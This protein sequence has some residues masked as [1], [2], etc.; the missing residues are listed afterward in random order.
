MDIL[1]ILYWDAKVNPS[2]ELFC[3][4]LKVLFRET[5]R[6]LLLQLCLPS[7]IGSGVID[8]PKQFGAS[9]FYA[10]VEKHRVF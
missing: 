5:T 10:P 2:I 3:S 1:Y 9:T 7:L 8:G 6:V 4:L